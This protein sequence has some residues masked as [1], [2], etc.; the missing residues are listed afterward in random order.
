MESPAMPQ[1]PRRPAGAAPVPGYPTALLAPTLGLVAATALGAAEPQGP[2][3]G[4]VVCAKPAAT[5]PVQP[6]APLRGEAPPVLPAPSATAPAMP[7]GPMLG[8]PSVPG[9][10]K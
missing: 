9:P 8:A 10:A 1:L 7:R 4:D 2:M 5:A 6:A 3:P